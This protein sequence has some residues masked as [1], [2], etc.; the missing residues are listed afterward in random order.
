MEPTDAITTTAYTLM[1][2]YADGRHYLSGGNYAVTER[3]SLAADTLQSLRKLYPAAFEAAEERWN[4]DR[5]LAGMAT[6][7]HATS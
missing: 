3:A 5:G 7:Y 6:I 4:N 2:A 1:S